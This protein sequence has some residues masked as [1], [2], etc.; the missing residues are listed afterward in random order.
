MNKK[1]DLFIQISRVAACLGVCTVH[2]AQNCHVSGVGGALM[3]MGKYGLFVFFV[4]SGYLVC[5]WNG[6]E[7]RV[8]KEKNHTAD[9]CVL[10]LADRLLCHAH[11]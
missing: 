8:Y 6:G 10:S 4:L 7:N 2:I 3:G 1:R 11:D 5:T 9:A